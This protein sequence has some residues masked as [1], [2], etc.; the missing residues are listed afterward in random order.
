MSG[1]EHREH[2]VMPTG[3]DPALMRQDGPYEMPARRIHAVPH[4]S[5]M[6]QADDDPGPRLPDASGDADLAIR[7]GILLE[8]ERALLASAVGVVLDLDPQLQV[9]AVEANSATGLR[10]ILAADADVVLV[11]SIPLVLRLREERPQL[12][13]IVLG[14]AG[15]AAATLAS[16]RAGAAGCVDENTSPALLVSI[17]RRAHA[18]EIV[19]EPSVLLDLLQRP[20]M[21]VEARPRRT[22]KLSER[23]LEVLSVLA[24]GASSAEVADALSISLNTMRTHLKNI[25]VKLEA[26]SKLEAVIIA[27]RE[28]RIEVPP[29]TR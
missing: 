22:S 14:A 17:V 23:E 21:P 13:V 6:S 24:M 19:Y 5:Q 8:P 9:V 2:E 15:D 28:G 26:R 11:D 20:S 10:R 29:E 1:L 25:L 7:V 16:I 4:E 27:I 12:R 18:G 3:D